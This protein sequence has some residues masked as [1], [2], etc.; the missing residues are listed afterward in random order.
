MIMS[1]FILTKIFLLTF[2]KKSEVTDNVVLFVAHLFAQ[3]LRIIYF[4]VIRWELV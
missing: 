3:L 4:L 2:E 1:A